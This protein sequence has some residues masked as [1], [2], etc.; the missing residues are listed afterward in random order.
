MQLSPEK[1]TSTT[2][3]VLIVVVGVEGV[4][5]GISCTRGKM[6][7]AL[8]KG[9]GI[10]AMGFGMPI[11]GC[12]MPG[13]GGY[14]PMAGWGIFIMGC[15]MPIMGFTMPIIGLGIPIMR[16]IIPIIGLGIPIMRVGIIGINDNPGNIISIP[17]EPGPITIFNGEDLTI[18]ITSAPPPGIIIPIPGVIVLLLAFCD[19][20]I[21]QRKIS[22]DNI[23]PNNLCIATYSSELRP[24]REIESCWAERRTAEKDIEKTIFASSLGI[25]PAI[26]GKVIRLKVP[27]LSTERRQQLVTQCKKMA[28]ASKVTVRNARRDGNKKAD[29]AKTESTLT[30]DDCKKCK[31]EIQD[32]TKKYEG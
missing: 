23:S 30:E 10:P 11:M 28:E 19:R 25:T 9:W 32:L 7:G 2:S 6:R 26:D 13:M 3:A 12:V 15:C 18:F 14:M 1:G 17:I 8:G 16:F 24:C 21:N 20:I 29:K 5:E 31:D 27:P 4:V 22:L